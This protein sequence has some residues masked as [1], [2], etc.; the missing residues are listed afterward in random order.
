[1]ADQAAPVIRA[2][3]LVVRRGGRVVLDRLDIDIER[4]SPF[5]IVGRSGSG[6][7]TLLMTLAGLW[8]IDA[9]TVR[10]DS[11][12][13]ADLAPR[14]RARQIG[15]VFQDH[16][17]FPH[18]TAL[19]NVTLAPRLAERSDFE[20]AA[21]KL[22]DDLGLEGLA[23]RRSHELSG[24]QRQRVA[25]ARTLALEPR[26]VLFDEPSAALDPKTS[27]DLAAL[28]VALAVRTQVIV[29]SHDIAFVTDCCDRGIRLEAGTVAARGPVSEI[30]EE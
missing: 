22:L 15:I 28:L 2:E 16:Q 20:A 8:P 10:V 7:T 13:L 5:A 24:G 3:G 9:G 4:G 1:M 21:R 14:E 17:L 30:V 6:K 11:T 26:V 19:E 29:V 27:R 12:A 18:L 23:E 25:I